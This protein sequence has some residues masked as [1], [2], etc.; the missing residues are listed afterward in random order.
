MRSNHFFRNFFLWVFLFMRRYNYRF[1]NLSE[2]FWRRFSKL[3]K[4][5]IRIKVCNHV[6]I[7]SLKWFWNIWFPNLLTHNWSL[8]K[9]FFRL[10]LNLNV[11]LYFRWLNFLWCSTCWGFWGVIVKSL[12]KNIPWFW[13]SFPLRFNFFGR[14]RRLVLNIFWNVSFRLYWFLKPCLRLSRLITYCV[15]FWNYFFRLCFVLIW[16]W[17]LN[18]LLFLIARIPIW[19]RLRRPWRLFL[20]FNI[21]LWRT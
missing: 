19:K 4:V 3:T 2:F 20:L 12:F 7:L 21:S 14:W 6:W 15:P 1:W 5:C 16:W 17:I 13:W 11:L 18:L 9:I 10:L 8:F